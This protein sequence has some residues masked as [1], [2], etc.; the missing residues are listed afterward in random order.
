MGDACSLGFL[1]DLNRFFLFVMDK[2]TEYF[3]SFPTKTHA[4]PLALLKQIVT[5]TTAAGEPI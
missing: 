3:V 5:L 2:G 1:P 4:S